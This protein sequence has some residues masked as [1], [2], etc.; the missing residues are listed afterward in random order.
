MS[1][2]TSLNTFP[3]PLFEGGVLD[4][5]I[6]RDGVT[7]KDDG[8]FSH[9]TDVVGMFIDTFQNLSIQ[10]GGVTFETCSHLLKQKKENKDGSLFLCVLLFV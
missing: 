7:T 8:H 2:F 9:L 5:I 10:K 3:F 4:G 6:E 1:L